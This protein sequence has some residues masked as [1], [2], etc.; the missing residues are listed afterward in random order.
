MSSSAVCAGAGRTPVVWPKPPAASA[1]AQGEDADRHVGEGE[2]AERVAFSSRTR[3]GSDTIPGSSATRAFGTGVTPSAGEHAAAHRS[4]AL[5]G[6]VEQELLALAADARRQ[7]HDLLGSRMLRGQDDLADARHEVEVEAAV[8]V[9]A[10]RRD[11]EGE[12]RSRDGQLQRTLV[13]TPRPSAFRTWPNTRAPSE[14]AMANRLWSPAQD[15]PR[16]VDRRRRSSAT[17]ERARRRAARDRGRRAGRSA[18][19]GADHG[20]RLDRVVRLQL[21]GRRGHRLVEEDADEQAVGRRIADIAGRLTVR[22]TKL[23][24]A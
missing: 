5:E 1:R 24:H 6:R 2:L 11:V 23:S 3:G 7:R 15:V 18:A 22:P 4:R 13:G 19:A 14:S 10:D 8:G 21:G 16:D 9:G 12:R 17:A 20:V